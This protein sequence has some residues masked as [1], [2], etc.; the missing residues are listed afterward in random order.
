MKKQDSETPVAVLLW[1]LAGRLR[2]FQQ[3]G[4]VHI[5]PLAH[6]GG[7][8]RSIEP[9]REYQAE[10]CVYMHVCQ[11]L[12]VRRQIGWQV[13]KERAGLAQPFK[14]AG[15]RVIRIADPRTAAA[16][17]QGGLQKEAV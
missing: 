12:R 16:G 2:G 5:S 11:R 15:I 1:C 6:R 10:V 8:Q 14:G 9:S 3:R 4:I 13:I 7:G 17:Y